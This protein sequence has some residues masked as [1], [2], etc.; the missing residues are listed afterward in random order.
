MTPTYRT[1]R[2]DRPDQTRRKWELR[3]AAVL[4]G[5]IL[6]FLQSSHAPHVEQVVARAGQVLIAVAVAGRAWCTL[7][8]GGRK[9]AMLVNAGPYSVSRNPLYVFSFVGAFGAGLQ[10]GSVVF[11]LVLLA[12]VVVAL[13]RTVVKEEEALGRKFGAAFEAYRRAVPRYGPGRRWRDETT[14][15]VPLP[16]VYRTVRD[17]M[18]LFLM[19]P[20][21][22]AVGWL[23][24]AGLLPVLLVLP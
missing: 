24:S 16:L 1:D 19:V 22:M 23:Q 13:H 4:L 18:L 9:F 21:T 15:T 7:Y 6:L 3:V 2:A 17:G 10:S 12:A 14:V 5:A 8:I 20:A 11:A